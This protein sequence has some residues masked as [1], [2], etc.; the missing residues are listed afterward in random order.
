MDDPEHEYLS[1]TNINGGR[2][3][4]HINETIKDVMQDIIDPNKPATARRE[5]TIKIGFVPTKSRR[6]SDIDYVVN[7]KLASMEKEKSSCNVRKKKD[8]KA[9]A[10][11]EHIEQQ[12][13]DLTAGEAGAS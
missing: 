8:G 13:L 6:E 3:A 5:I 7:A 12:E 4:S 11:V 2:L 10:S 1:V 9:F